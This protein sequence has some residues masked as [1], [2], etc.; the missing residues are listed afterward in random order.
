MNY[1]SPI[2]PTKKT[3][4]TSLEDYGKNNIYVA[5]PENRLEYQDLYDAYALG[6]NKLGLLIG[7]A[8]YFSKELINLKDSELKKVYF[9]AQ[10]INRSV[11]GC[12]GGICIL[13]RY[14]SSSHRHI[15]RDDNPRISHGKNILTDKEIKNISSFEYWNQNTVSSLK[16]FLRFYITKLFNETDKKIIVTSIPNKN[17]K[18]RFEG[19][20]NNLNTSKNKK[21]EGRL[22][23]YPNLFQVV[24]NLTHSKYSGYGERKASL[25]DAYDI[26]IS[27]DE[28]SNSE[29]IIID[30]VFTTGA[31]LEEC[32]RALS[33]KASKYVVH[34]VFLAAT[35]RPEYIHKTL[36]DYGIPKIIEID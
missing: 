26:S 9:T 12:K 25:E 30:D 31:H 1:N 23:Y 21:Y 3:F 7:E 36:I 6:N 13:G 32:L 16:D 33:K 10:F 17:K 8:S 18:N 29:I 14:F 20:L 27:F 2:F 22:Y 35:Q 19:L 34:G 5:L 4:I 15:S 24:K 11:T 28:L